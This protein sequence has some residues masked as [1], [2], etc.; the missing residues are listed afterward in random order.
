MGLLDLL[1]IFLSFF[2]LEESPLS[3]FR[4]RDLE[5]L[6]LSSSVDSFFVVVCFPRLPGLSIASRA[7]CCY[8]VRTL[9]PLGGRVLCSVMR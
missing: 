9:G 2:G 8:G 7:V 4:F 1:A 3:D 6:V 5:A